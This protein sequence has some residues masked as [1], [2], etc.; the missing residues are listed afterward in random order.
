MHLKG[1]V[2]EMSENRI[3]GKEPLLWLPSYWG[4]R[5]LA[6]SQSSVLPRIDL[7]KSDEVILDSLRGFVVF[8]L[9]GTFFT[10]TLVRTVTG[11][12]RSGKK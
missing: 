7:I 12:D 4:R 11:L 10:S 1:F 9:P 8:V 2:G 6:A 5:P 3:G